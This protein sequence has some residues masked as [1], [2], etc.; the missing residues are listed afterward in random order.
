[1]SC[2]I[3]KKQKVTL[4]PQTDKRNQHNQQKTTMFQNSPPIQPIQPNANR[5]NGTTVEIGN[6][7]S[8]YQ[9]NSCNSTNMSKYLFWDE[10]AKQDVN[11]MEIIPTENGDR[12]IQTIQIAVKDSQKTVPDDD[13]L[14]QYIFNDGR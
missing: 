3:K 8:H 9:M 14:F 12:Y 13:E 6:N 10:S 5:N 11:I 1:M 7:S 4:E 2:T